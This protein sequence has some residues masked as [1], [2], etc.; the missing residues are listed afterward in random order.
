MIE[1]NIKHTQEITHDL[2]SELYG[3]DTLRAMAALSITLTHIS[4]NSLKIGLDRISF[5]STTIGVNVFFVLSG[6]LI[7]HLTIKQTVFNKQNIVNFYMRRVLR[8]WPLYY[9]YLGL[10]LICTVLIKPAF[11]NTNAIKYYLFLCP[12]V[13]W[14][15][16]QGLPFLH[17]YWSLGVE[18]QFYLFWPLLVYV[19]GNRLLTATII[20]FITLFSIN[21]YIY[22]F[23]H[24][25]LTSSFIYACQYHTLLIG[26]IGAILMQKY[27]RH[28]IYISKQ[29]LL[30]AFAWLLL[31]YYQLG[32]QCFAQFNEMVV[33]LATLLILFQLIHRQSFK[34]F[35]D[36]VVFRH[37]GRISFGIYVFHP[38]IIGIVIYTIRKMNIALPY[39]IVFYVLVIG[40]TIAIAH[41]SYTYFESRF[42]KLKER[43]Y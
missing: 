8:I 28:V 39:H 13:P 9:S 16:D 6:F 3:L 32:W 37:I 40:L 27:P 12:N 38:L 34:I 4:S 25:N 19:S 35:F 18:E 11:I 21:V 24:T 41:L 23:A 15:L 43:F 10:A 36:N 29:W 20:A 14:I 2:K 30:M 5:F 42:L 31:L 22:S 17:H 33:A 1:N 7:T 26:C